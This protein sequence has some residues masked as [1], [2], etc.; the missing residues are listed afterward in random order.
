MV[1]DSTDY[2]IQYKDGAPRESPLAMFSSYDVKPALCLDCGVWK[3]EYWTG[4]WEQIGWCRNICSNSTSINCLKLLT[5]LHHFYILFLY[6]FC[7]EPGSQLLLTFCSFNLSLI[8]Y[9]GSLSLKLIRAFEEN[10][11]KVTLKKTE[12][13]DFSLLDYQYIILGWKKK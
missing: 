10:E 2:G 5:L 6:N 4:L 8:W 9:D 13:E 11:I 7:M 12:D 1:Q 3:T